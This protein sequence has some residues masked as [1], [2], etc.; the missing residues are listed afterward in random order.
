MIREQRVVLTSSDK[1]PNL[2]V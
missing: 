2:Y 1:K